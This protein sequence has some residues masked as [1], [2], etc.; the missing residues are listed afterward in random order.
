MWT[1]APIQGLAGQATFRLRNVK[2]DPTGVLS[3]IQIPKSDLLA[4]CALEQLCMKLRDRGFSIDH[5]ETGQGPYAS[6]RCNM[7]DALLFLVLTREDGEQ[8]SAYELLV[9]AARKYER[10][11]PFLSRQRTFPPSSN[12]LSMWEALHAAVSEGLVRDL[13]V[14][15]LQWS[16]QRCFAPA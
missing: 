7:A 3:A 15:Q 10:K 8:E 4:A 6:C 16:T 11:L 12:E 1:H 9:S 14:E 5:A 2:V 13:G